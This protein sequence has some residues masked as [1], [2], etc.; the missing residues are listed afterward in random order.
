[1]YIRK[2]DTVVVTSGRYK[3]RRGRV[4]EVYPK[5]ET[6]LVEGVNIRKHHTKPG[7][8]HQSGGIVER[9]APIHIS[10]VMGWC[11]EKQQPSQIKMKTLADGR[12]VRVWKLTGE[13]LD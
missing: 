9:E 4:L 8:T 2:K 1:M 7:Q 11:E 12:R 3:G 10:N 5:K 6:I 13:V